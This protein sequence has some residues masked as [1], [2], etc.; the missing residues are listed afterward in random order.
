MFLAAN[1]NRVT[2]I[3]MVISLS[4]VPR[5]CNGAGGVVCLMQIRCFAAEVVATR[6]AQEEQLARARQVNTEG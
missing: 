2:S 3:C 1:T 4:F 6:P 5:Q